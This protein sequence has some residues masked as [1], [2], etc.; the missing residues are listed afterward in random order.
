VGYAGLISGEEGALYNLLSSPNAAGELRRLT[1]EATLAGQLYALWGLEVLGDERFD[2]LSA[3]HASDASNVDTQSGCL[4][5]HEAV[6]VI[7]E[8][9]RRGDYGKP[10][11]WSASGLVGRIWTP[12][13]S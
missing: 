10:R 6:A 1:S 9:I 7:V 13:A 4:V 8:R 12:F 2:E 5:R 3:A 11:R